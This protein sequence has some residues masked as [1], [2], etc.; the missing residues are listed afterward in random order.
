MKVAIEQIFNGSIPQVAIG[1]AYDANSIN[2][3]KHTGQFNLGAGETDKFVGPAPLGVA[4]LAES[5][6]AIPSQFVHPV[7]I[8]DDLFWIFGSDAATAAAT[9]R[10]QLWT[11]VPSTNTY[12]FRGAITCTFPTATVHTVRGIRV[13]LENYT[14][15]T[16]GVSGTAVTGTGTAWNTGLSVGSRIGF[17]STD[18]QAITT[19]YQISAIGSDTSIT[20][21]SSAGT[22]SAGTPYVIQD[23]MIVQATTNATA[24]NGGLFVTKGLQFADFQNPATAIPAATTVDRIKATYWLKDAATITNDVIGG[25]ALGD[26]DSWTQQYVYS[27]EGSASSLILYRY[28]IRTPLT[29]TAGAFTLTG[30]DIVITGTQAVTG[31]ISQANNGRVATLQH[32]AGAGVTSLYLFT[33]TRILRVPLVNITSG[34]TTFVADTMSEVSPGGTNTN[35]TTGTFTSFDVAGS[36]DKLVISAGLSSGTIYITDYYTGGQQIDRRAGCCTLQLPSALR[37]RDSSIFVHSVGANLPFIWVEDGWLFWIYSQS[38]TTTI[39]SLTAYPLAADLEYQADVNNRVILPKISLG[40]VPCNFYRILVNC[41]KNIGDDRFGLTPDMYTV[42]YRI[43]GIDDNSG[44]WFDV[45]QDG[46]LS[47]IPTVANVQFALRFRTA[48]VMMLPA[49]ILSVAFLYETDDGIPSQ[50]RWDNDDFNLT[51]NTFAFKQVERFYSTPPVHNIEIY[52]Q[53]TNAL[54]LTQNSLNNTNGNFQYWN[55]TT[56]VNGLDG[57]NIGLRRRFVPT[58]SLPA[59]SLYAK[60]CCYT[61]PSI[62]TSGLVLHLDAGNVASYPGTGG[63][64]FDLSGNNYNGSLN[65][66]SWSPGSGGVMVYPGSG[67]GEVI[68]P[69]NTNTTLNNSSQTINQWINITS[70]GPNSYSE[71]Y[72]A[73]TIFSSWVCIQFQA[74]GAAL[75][76]S[77]F[78]FYNVTGMSNPF[79]QWMNIC[80]IINRTGNSFTVYKNGVLV[81]TVATSTF[82][83]SSNTVRI[84]SNYATGNTTPPHGDNMDG[85]LGN[86][87]VYNRTLSAAEILQNFNALRG[88]YGL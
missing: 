12:T 9:R 11:W 30:T 50:Y 51:N 56:W 13:I 28:N 29:P 48:G 77:G 1:G 66:V 54:V 84:G 16:V 40:S 37:E 18:P 75:F 67:Y 68:L 86:T 73:G 88:R 57:D 4:N 33:T 3:G 64:W 19:W 81:G 79:N 72:Y 45:P 7:K 74:T 85:Q 82:T 2:R 24:T 22:I 35:V 10:V 44:A 49:R 63:T 83:N 59:T 39:N 47:T 62:V 87:F 20:L 26:R 27:T 32:G 58:A 60:M 69:V 17:G 8:T 76:I 38:T 71:L 5:S 80:C 34:N 23:L 6:L 65:S 46:D 42:E 53:D 43:T 55:G 61:I 78:L 31:T 21:T 25:C 14:T 52:R 36:L 15:G 41:V 70:F